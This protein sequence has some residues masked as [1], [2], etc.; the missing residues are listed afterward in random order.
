MS[1][2]MHLKLLYNHHSWW[3]SLSS[4]HIDEHSPYKILLPALVCDVVCQ[5][6]FTCWP[7][8]SLP[9][10]CKGQVDSD[11]TKCQTP[12]NHSHRCPH[13]P[14]DL[15]EVKGSHRKFRTVVASLIGRDHQRS[16]SRA[17][18][19]MKGAQRLPLPSEGSHSKTLCEIIFVEGFKYIATLEPSIGGLPLWGWLKGNLD[20]VL[21]KQTC[22]VAQGERVSI[23]MSM[24]QNKASL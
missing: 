17:C 4:V 13:P 5:L 23:W 2:A 6:I 22:K 12:S 18:L 10:Q 7:K 24:S 14:V 8:L 3:A 20:M 9:R 1:R 19:G 21:W 15:P 11:Q 16:P